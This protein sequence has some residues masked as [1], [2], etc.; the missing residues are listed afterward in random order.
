MHFK[1]EMIGFLAK[2]SQKLRI[3][4]NF[5]LTVFELTVPDL[6]NKIRDVLLCQI[7][8]NKIMFILLFICDRASIAQSVRVSTAHYARVRVPK[9]LEIVSR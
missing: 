4:W 9:I 3:K 1:H 6:Y 2:Y 7:L 8:K 5:E